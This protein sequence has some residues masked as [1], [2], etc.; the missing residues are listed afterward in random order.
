MVEPLL[1]EGVGN[2]GGG[3]TMAAGGGGVYFG[4]VGGDWGTM[5]VLAGGVFTKEGP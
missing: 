1:T 5:G 3:E 2:T 4:C